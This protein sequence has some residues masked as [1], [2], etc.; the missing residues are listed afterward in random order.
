MTQKLLNFCFFNLRNYIIYS[1]YLQVDPDN[2]RLIEEGNVNALLEAEKI[3]QATKEAL[4][5][6]IAQAAETDLQSRTLPAKLRIDPNDP[7]DVVCSQFL[8]ELHE[9]GYSGLKILFMVSAEVHSFQSLKTVQCS[10]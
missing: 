2:V 1:H 5:R 8:F 3:A 9:G 7:E 10:C 4:K 6:K